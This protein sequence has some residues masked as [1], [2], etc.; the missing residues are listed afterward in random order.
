MC[1]EHCFFGLQFTKIKQII[2]HIFEQIM[3]KILK[4]IVSA[5]SRGL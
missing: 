1:E 2:E 5:F 3:G 4:K